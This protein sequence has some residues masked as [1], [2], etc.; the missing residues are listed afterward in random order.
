ELAVWD[1]D[2]VS[3]VILLDGGFMSMGDRMDWDTA[4]E[5]LAPPPLSGLGID[6][7]LSM[8]KG[9][10]GDQLEYTPAVERVSRSL[11]RVD[12][13]GRI[14]PRLS[15][16]NH[17]RILRAMWEEYP[18]ALLRRVNVPT[19]VVGTRREGAEGPDAM[20][21]AAKE[22]GRQDVE[23]IGPPVRFRWIEGI[24]DLPLQRPD[25]VAA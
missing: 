2:V 11:M 4:K 24:H 20:F 14:H 10:M 25:A 3:G 21:I 18:P 16:A 8:V 15:R 22:L 9:F 17:L 19:L 5:T 23:R 12:R 7:Y 13:E 1:P 6:E